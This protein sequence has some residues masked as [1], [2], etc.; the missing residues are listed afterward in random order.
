MAWIGIGI[1][2]MLGFYL[3]PII[4]GLCIVV[5]TVVTSAV[6]AVFAAIFKGK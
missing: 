3:A 1:L 6:F 4:L 5:L 2:I